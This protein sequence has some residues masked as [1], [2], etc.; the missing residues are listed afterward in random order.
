[1]YKKTVNFWLY[2]MGSLLLA[3]LLVSLLVKVVKVLLFWLLVLVITPIIYI[4]LRYFFQ[5]RSLND[6][7]S[8]LKYRS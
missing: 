8:K 5:P 7:A 3:V 2:L 4:L 6:K 1:M